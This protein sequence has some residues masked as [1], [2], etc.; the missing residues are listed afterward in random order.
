MDK[1]FIIIAPVRYVDGEIP[2]PEMISN[3]VYRCWNAGASIVHLHVTDSYGNP[4]SDLSLFNCTVGLIRKKCDIIIQP[5]TGAI[6]SISVESRTLVAEIEEVEQASLNM[7]SLNLYGTIFKNSEED[8]R[9]IA[10]KL[11]EYGVKP[12]LEIFNSPMIDFA[13]QLKDEG[14]LLD[15]LSF[16]LYIYNKGEGND[17]GER[18]IGKVTQKQR[19]LISELESIP[20]NY[21]VSICNHDY[22]DLSMFALAISMGLSIRVGFE[23]SKHISPTELANDNAEIVEK[24]VKILKF[25]G[26]EPAS[27]YETRKILGIN[28]FK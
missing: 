28:K 25:F 5:S 1:R 2:S 26:T 9:Y 24:I 6:D 7:G 13:L 17:Y 21:P 22:K 23:D 15:P 27:T 20:P 8:I 18:R 11:K 19:K 16:Q 3:I 14:L 12:D 10:K 4:T